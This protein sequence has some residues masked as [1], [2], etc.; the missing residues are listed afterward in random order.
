[1]CCEHERTNKRAFMGNTNTQNKLLAKQQHQHYTVYYGRA[2]HRKT[3]LI[4]SL[5]HL[6]SIN[7]HCQSQ[8]FFYNDISFFSSHHPS[9]SVSFYSI[10]PFSLVRSCYLDLL[11]APNLFCYLY[12]NLWKMLLL[13][14]CKQK[15]V[16]KIMSLTWNE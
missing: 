9:L 14:F 5:H 2:S 15:T 13:V 1:M 7:Y 6:I 8:L 10:S 16:E 3:N 11:N 12:K 4:A